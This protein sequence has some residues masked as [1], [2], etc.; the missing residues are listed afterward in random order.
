MS[1]DTY[2]TKILASSATGNAPDFGT[3]QNGRTAQWAKQGVT[4]ALE[5]ALK[6]AGLDL[7]DFDQRSLDV[8]TYYGSLHMLP[9]DVTSMA[10]LLNVPFSKSAG[11]VVSKPPKTGAELIEWAQKMTLK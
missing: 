9:I 11:L 10:E 7:A 3:A 5:P 2:G 8:C 4:Y 1:D 6:A